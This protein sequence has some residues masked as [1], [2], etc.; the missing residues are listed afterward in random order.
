M[1]CAALNHEYANPGLSR[2]LLLRSLIS[3]LI[4]WVSRRDQKHQAVG[5]GLDRGQSYLAAFSKLIEKHYR[6]HLPISHYAALLGITPVYL[7]AVCQRLARQRAL[8]IVHQRLLLEAK[9]N[10]IYTTLN[11]SQIAHLL[12]FSEPAYFTRFFKR[13]TGKSPNVF[14]SER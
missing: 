3:A 6:K 2:D 10:L 12:G 5:E 13:L 1:L 8:S 7:N 9:R 11:V 14:R 4:I